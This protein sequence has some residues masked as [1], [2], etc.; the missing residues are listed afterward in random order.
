MLVTPGRAQGLFLALCSV[1]NPG[2]TQL[3]L[4]DMVP[5]IQTRATDDTVTFKASVFPPAP[6]LSL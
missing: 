6:A 2:S 4:Q 1:V 3:V 5:R